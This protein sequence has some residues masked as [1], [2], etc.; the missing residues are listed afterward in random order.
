M[1]LSNAAALA[2]RN[3]SQGS[4]EVS[5]LMLRKVL[6]IQVSQSAQL[7]QMVAQSSGLGQSIDIKV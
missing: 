5:T 7:A 2:S 4:S 3:A 1:E 6:D